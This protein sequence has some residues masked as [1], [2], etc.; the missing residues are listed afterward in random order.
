M[1]GLLY[2]QHGT[3]DEL[4]RRDGLNILLEGKNCAA[5]SRVFRQPGCGFSIEVKHADGAGE[6][7]DNVSNGEGRMEGDVSGA[8]RDA[9]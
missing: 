4:T 3:G 2:S 7:V 5:A 1:F 8:V 9:A 6:L